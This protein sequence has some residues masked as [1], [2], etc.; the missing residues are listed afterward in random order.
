MCINEWFRNRA[1][2]GK[3][4]AA[5]AIHV[6]MSLLVK[7]NFVPVSVYFM[8]GIFDAAHCSRTNRHFPVLLPAPGFALQVVLGAV[9]VCVCVC[10][11]V[12]ACVPACVPAR[13]PARVLACLPA[14]RV[15]SDVAVMCQCFLGLAYPP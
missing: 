14:N 7:S 4:Y 2:L 11:C 8:G 15:S 1:V 6:K 3:C 13:V 12:R 9:W 5:S 10:V